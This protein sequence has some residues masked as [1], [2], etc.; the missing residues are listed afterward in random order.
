M[1]TSGL[2]E[3]LLISISAT[4]D[5]TQG[6]DIEDLPDSIELAP[7]ESLATLSVK[8]ID[9]NQIEQ[10]ES[11]NLFFNVAESNY[12]LEV[13]EL[14][15]KIEDDDRQGTLVTDDFNQPSGPVTTSSEWHTHSGAPET[16]QIIDEALV[17]GGPATEDIHTIIPGAPFLPDEN[18]ILFS[19]FDLTLIQPIT[20]AGT[21]FAHF[22]GTSKTAFHSRIHIEAK[23]TEGDTFQLGIHGGRQ[24]E[25]NFHPDQLELFIPYRVI[26]GFD[27]HSGESTLWINA[28]NENAVGA[29]STSETVIP[30][31]ESFA[32]RQTGTE[33]GGIGRLQIDNL[34]LGTSFESVQGFVPSLPSI[35]IQAEQSIASEENADAGSWSITRSGDLSKE[36]RVEINLSGDAVQTED[37]HILFSSEE[38][39]FQAGEESIQLRLFPI[40]DT[41]DEQEE[42]AI[43]TLITGPGYI[44][45]G[46]RFASIEIRDNDATGTEPI[47]VT[48]PV[49]S[50]SHKSIEALLLPGVHYQLQE[51]EDLARWKTILELTGEGKNLSHPLDVISGSALFFRLVA[52]R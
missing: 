12:M 46:N 31:I 33:N 27:I 35:S 48:Q 52:D 24:G 21:Y 1:R 8:I 49:I 10:T 30:P 38:I 26:M 50:I 13:Q 23:Q 47:P 20:G 6:E 18:S 14:N 42:T 39:V 32:F 2:E 5:S 15:L 28:T 34:S 37:Y 40:D 22:K 9:D 16:T 11:L 44:I 3:P 51:S 41:L 17:L 36:L 25:P 45:E 43:L 19:G 7:L 4:G 29:Q